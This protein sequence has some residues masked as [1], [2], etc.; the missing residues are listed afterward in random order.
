MVVIGEATVKSVLLTATPIV[1]V[2]G[3]IPISLFLGKI[4]KK[5]SSSL[6][7]GIIDANRNL[8]K[9]KIINPMKD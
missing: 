1:F 4:F 6:K 2:P 7:I 5:N 9:I 3:S 8:L